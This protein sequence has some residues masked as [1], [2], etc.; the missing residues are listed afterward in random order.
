MQATSDLSWSP[1]L[2]SSRPS[3]ATLGAVS[4]LVVECHIADLSVRGVAC[5][6]LR[7]CGTVN[8]SAANNRPIGYTLN[9]LL[10]NR[11]VVGFGHLS[12]GS[13]PTK[14]AYRVCWP[15]N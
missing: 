10:D 2:Y 13:S 8:G 5:L 6:A 9:V 7:V 3:F 12:T 11:A 15:S 14:L 4:Y 1:F